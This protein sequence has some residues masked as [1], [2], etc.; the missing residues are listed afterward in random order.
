M[1]LKLRM[2]IKFDCWLMENQYFSHA[3]ADCYDFQSVTLIIS[4]SIQITK[5][6]RTWWHSIIVYYVFSSLSKWF[7]IISMMSVK[8]GI[9]YITRLVSAF[10]SN[11]SF[12]CWQLK[13]NMKILV[14]LKNAVVFSIQFYSR[15]FYWHSN[16]TRVYGRHNLNVSIQFDFDRIGIPKV[17]VKFGRNSLFSCVDF[18]F[19]EL[20]FFFCLSLLAANVSVQ[21]EIKIESNNEQSRAQHRTMA[22]N[23]LWCAYEIWLLPLET[24]NARTFR[25]PQ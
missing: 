12:Y 3:W 18:C 16:K 9:L 23:C 20:I 7:I 2:L 5:A 21:L 25:C 1:E 24:F 22:V 10:E 19:I 8:R 4:I 15:R 14:K 6:I 11:A 13:S 17:Q